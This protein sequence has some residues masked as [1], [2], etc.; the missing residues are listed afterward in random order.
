MGLCWEIRLD[1]ICFVSSKFPQCHVDWDKIL[2]WPGLGANECH[3]RIRN[4]PIEDILARGNRSPHGDQR[5]VKYRFW[6]QIP[7]F[8]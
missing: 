1:V 2:C 4:T 6:T 8:N 3:R 7:P 5:V